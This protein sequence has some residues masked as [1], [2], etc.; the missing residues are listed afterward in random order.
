MMLSFVHLLRCFKQR[1]VLNDISYTFPQRGLVSITGP[2]GCGKTTLLNILAGIDEKYEGEIFF[3]SKFLKQMSSTEL[4]EYRLKSIGYVFQDF[5][6]FNLD[7]VYGNVVLPLETAT[8]MSKHAKKRKV[9]DL[10]SFVELNDKIDEK[11]AFLSGGEKQRVAIARSLINEPSILLLDEPSGSLDE[12]TS[13]KIF[14]LLK[15][16]S[17]FTCVIVVTHD[18]EIANKYSDTIVHM[19]DGNIT[20]IEN[21]RNKI[22]DCEPLAMIKLKSSPKKA[23]IPNSF[24]F[25]HIIANIKYKKGRTFFTT[26]MTSFGLAGV[27]LTL[28]LSSSLSTEIKNSFNSVIDDRQ[29][30]ASLK[31]DGNNSFSS[32]YSTNENEVKHICEKYSSRV[33][34]Y[35][36]SYLVNYEDFFRSQ[37][38]FF[39]SS[40]TYRLVIDELSSRSI[41]E[42]VWE[43]DISSTIFPSPRDGMENDQILLQ[44]SYKTMVNLCYR[45]H[46]LR[47]YESFGQYINENDIFVTIKIA[48]DNWTYNDEQTFRLIGVCEGE[49]TT[50][51]HSNHRWNKWV[52]EDEMRIPTTL[53]SDNVPY[54]WEMNKVFYMKSRGDATAFLNELMHDQSMNDYVFERGDDKYYKELV[55]NSEN[56]DRIFAFYVDKTCLAISEIDEFKRIEPR[57]LT[58][59]ILTE[60]GYAMFSSLMLG[61]SNNF[62]IS[63]SEI[64]LDQAI[65]ADSK[66]KSVDMKIDFPKSVV[67]GNVLNSACGGLT[68]SSNYNRNAD[69][70]STLSLD[71]IAISSSLAKQL[72]VDVGSDVYVSMVTNSSLVDETIDKQYQKDCL[73]VADIVSENK[74]MIF[75]TSDWTVSYFRD[76]L[77]VSSFSLCPKSVIFDI[78]DASVSDSII[79]N[80]KSN[81][82]RYDFANPSR[83]IGKSIDET[84][85]YVKMMLIAFSSISF[86]ISFLLLSIVIYLS[87]IENQKEIVLMQ[88]IGIPEK[89]IKKLFVYYAI[90]ISL[91]SSLYATFELFFLSIIIKRTMMSYFGSPV[92]N[93]LN[94]IPYFVIFFISLII[95][96]F[97]GNTI[98]T[99]AFYARK[100]T[101]K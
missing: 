94:I 22:S 78:G 16:I 64:S 17:N 3:N 23:K 20:G 30:V 86:L 93:N 63:S 9:H 37:N 82:S 87:T 31:N 15:R 98:V 43:D 21:I 89:D 92:Q 52:F 13:E 100:K 18:I 45:L 99:I 36:L 96:Y 69:D 7:T 60:G 14:A 10:L 11:V 57:L 6:L 75:H 77:S 61:F 73:R 35:G 26:F 72:E 2:S 38:E 46:I 12:N 53:N 51:I 101:V 44:L 25:R 68:F 34:D 80:L 90:G 24:L 47:S 42:Y 41:N 54:P 58:Y 62:F 50:I 48:N 40:T 85:N 71:E 83:L 19:S 39:I 59:S 1:V 81:F 91:L 29:I 79:S 32:V 84:L 56:V 8:N 97:I 66:V 49:Q 27:G 4:S 5:N 95:A 65:D 70:G 28:L 67:M 33:L 88:Y 76:H 55:V 74:L